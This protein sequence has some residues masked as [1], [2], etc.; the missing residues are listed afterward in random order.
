MSTK[1]RKGSAHRELGV[2]LGLAALIILFFATRLY[3]FGDVPA[4]FH[5]DELGASYDA[6]CIAHYGVDRYMVRFPV[7]FQNFGAGQNALYTYLGALLFKFVSFSPKKFR[8]IAVFC[9]FL[10][11]I[12]SWLIS[13]KA[14]DKRKLSLTAP[15]LWCIT[16]V[17][18]MSERWGLESYLFISF[19]TMAICLLCYATESRGL[20]LWT[21][22]G[23]VTGLTLY[24]YGVSYVVI[25]LFLI[26]TYIYLLWTRSVGKKE[27]AAFVVPLALLG[28]PLIIEQFVTAEILPEFSFL[29]TDFKRMEFS[30][31]GEFGLKYIKHNLKDIPLFFTN[32]FLPYNGSGKYGTLLYIALPFLALGLIV[33]LFKAL[34]SIKE[35]RFDLSVLLIAFF[36]VSFSV[37]LCMVQ[38]NINRVNEVYF[39]FVFFEAYG[40]NLLWNR[41]KNAYIPVLILYLVFF[42]FFGRYYY[43]DRYNADIAADE[44]G[45]LFYNTDLG[46]AVKTLADYYDEEKVVNI[47]SDDAGERHILIADYCGT[48]PYEYATDSSTAGNYIIGLPEELDISGDTVYVIGKNLKHIADYLETVGFGVDGDTY[49]DYFVVMAP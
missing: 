8:F 12:A 2:Y 34:K 47:I 18:L 10:A 39:A 38:L 31:A 43:S 5:I 30:R 41:W 23:A 45:V 37:S 17:I 35:R 28:I 4:G 49:P 26:L 36:I 6:Q 1:K 15:F 24:T 7:Y 40:I 32:D 3:R 11:M 14:F 9:G 48:S 16:P 21:A 46:A 13:C 25:P 33:A 44:S 29:L 22:A 42:V 20:F 27:T 19:V